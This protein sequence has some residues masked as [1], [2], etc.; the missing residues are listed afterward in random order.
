MVESNANMV[1]L[2]WGTLQGIFVTLGGPPAP[3][4]S[5]KRSFDVLSATALVL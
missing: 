5:T 2:L 1:R 4:V 3:P